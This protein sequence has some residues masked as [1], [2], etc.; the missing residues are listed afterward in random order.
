MQSCITGGH[1]D[2]SNHGIHQSHVPKYTACG[3]AAAAEA[4]STVALA[5][6]A[7]PSPP[8]TSSP[9]ACR[10]WRATAASATTAARAPRLVVCPPEAAAGAVE[11][12]ATGLQIIRVASRVDVG[13]GDLSHFPIPATYNQ[14]TVN[15][16]FS[17]LAG[18]VE[19]CTW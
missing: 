7:S 15:M 6:F 5:T 9:T 16:C 13:A 17:I 4:E 10:G 11:C 14:S 12:A 18:N 3:A 1:V 8:A 19:L 2:R